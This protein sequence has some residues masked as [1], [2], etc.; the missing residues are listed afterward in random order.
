MQSEQASLSAGRLSD[1]IAEA[2]RKQ[3]KAVGKLKD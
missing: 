2:M 1:R 3:R